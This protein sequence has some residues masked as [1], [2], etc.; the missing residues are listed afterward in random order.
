MKS[1]LYRREAAKISIYADLIRNKSTFILLTLVLDTYTRTSGFLYS[2]PSYHKCQNHYKSARHRRCRHSS[3]DD[4]GEYRQY[5]K[6][7]LF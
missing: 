7:M 6:D 4:C 1:Y 5:E 3:Q 2:I